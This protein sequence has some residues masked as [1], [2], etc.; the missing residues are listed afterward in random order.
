MKV[1][2]DEAEYDLTNNAQA[3]QFF[4]LVFARSSVAVEM[5]LLATLSTLNSTTASLS[6]ANDA[7]RQAQRCL[8]DAIDLTV[9]PANKK[10]SAL[11]IEIE[12]RY[13]EYVGDNFPLTESEEK[14][15]SLLRKK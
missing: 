6:Q 7:H 11:L 13:L 2:L 8:A 14:Y 5:A 3:A 10:N 9:E 1:T 4:L 15:K 12:K